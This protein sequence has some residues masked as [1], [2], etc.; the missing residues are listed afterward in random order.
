MSTKGNAR[1]FFVN[2][3]IKK[4][5][6]EFVAHCLEL[7]LVA[8]ARTDKQVRSDIIDIVMAHIDYALYNDNLENMFHPAPKEIW[9]EFYACKQAFEQR[10]RFQSAFKHAEGHSFPD[11]I[12]ANMNEPQRSCH[13]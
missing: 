3:F 5:A 10:R 9:E 7:D 13:T 8:T 1:S 11:W 6:D 4:E 12:I 2:I